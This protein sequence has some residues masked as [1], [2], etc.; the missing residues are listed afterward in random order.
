MEAGYEPLRPPAA[1]G[2]VRGRAN[3]W[4]D[5]AAWLARATDIEHGFSKLWPW[6]A[7]TIDE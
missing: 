3:S 7:Q 6:P 2:E 4:P 5:R 1:V